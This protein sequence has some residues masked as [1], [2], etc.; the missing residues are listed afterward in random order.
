MTR[1]IIATKL[2]VPARRRG[3]VNRPRLIAR[4][5]RTVDVRLTLVS[6]PAGFG[7]TTLLGEWLA[8]MPADRQVAWLSIDPADNDPANFWTYVVAALQQA[9]PGAGSTA[10]ALIGSPPLPT[11]L[12]VTTVVNELAEASGDVWLVL[13]DYHLVDGPDV[14]D[15]MAFLLEHFPP[16]VHLVISSRADPLSRLLGWRARGELVEIR[17]ADLRFTPDEVATYLNDVIGLDLA[18]ETV[19]AL[20]ARTEGWVAAL[21]LA[22]ISMQGRDGHQRIHRPFA[23]NDR[24]IVDYLVEEV[25]AQQSDPVR[26]FLL[27]HGGS[28][29]AHRAAL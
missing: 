7:K 4:L 23:G 15:G 12:L 14:R 21:Q 16:H 2:H 27:A 26:E 19:A 25:L 5:R 20:E 6:A 24:Y 9:V 1:P 29:P 18:A 11:E 28:R 3:L 8:D 13:D 17:A 22:A 10:M